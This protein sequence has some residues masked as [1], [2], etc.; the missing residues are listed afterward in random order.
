MVHKKLFSL[1]IHL[2]RLVE[3][4]ITERFFWKSPLFILE[5]LV[6]LR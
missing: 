1:F 5:P 2:F 4:N 6:V 3:N